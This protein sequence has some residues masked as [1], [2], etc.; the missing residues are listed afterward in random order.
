M[1][2]IGYIYIYI[3]IEIIR[4]APVDTSQIASIRMGTTVATNALLER[5]GESCALVCEWFT[6]VFIVSRR[7]PLP[8]V[9]L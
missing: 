5:E 7:S 9:S 3:L 1:K 6:A 8:C 2:G 4:G